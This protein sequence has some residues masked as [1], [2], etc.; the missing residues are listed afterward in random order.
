MPV[1]ILQ[2]RSL[3]LAEH[4]KQGLQRRADAPIDE[5]K[6]NGRQD[7]HHENHDRGQHHLSSGRPNDF[8]HLGADLLN[9]LDR[10]CA[11][12]DLLF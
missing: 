4:A 1:E 3:S 5:E 8:G 11:G 9:E 10:I 6:E 7:C 12:H 2:E